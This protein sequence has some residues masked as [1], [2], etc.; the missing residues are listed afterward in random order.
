MPQSRAKIRESL[1]RVAFVVVEADN[2]EAAWE[3]AHTAMWDIKD[4]DFACTDSDMEVADVEEF[5]P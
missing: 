4:D 5:N 1:Y 3:K 2:E